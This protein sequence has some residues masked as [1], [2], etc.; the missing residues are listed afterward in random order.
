MELLDRLLSLMPVAGR[1]DIRCN[2]GSP[3]RI[4]H[5]ESNEWEFPYHVLLRG[6][7]VVESGAQGPV[8]AAAG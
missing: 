7:A 6:E 8:H 2:F 1:L 5:P 4:E 3:W